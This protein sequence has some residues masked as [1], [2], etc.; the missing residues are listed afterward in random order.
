M[1]KFLEKHSFFIGFAITLLILI[2]CVLGRND[3]D[4][5]VTLANGSTRII[6]KRHT[7]Q[8]KEDLISK[9]ILD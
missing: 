5:L 1:K 6:E 7:Y 9:G 8:V 2:F 3:E 4:V